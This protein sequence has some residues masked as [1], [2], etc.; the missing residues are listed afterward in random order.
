M[1]TP[2]GMSITK[3][4]IVGILGFL[5]GFGASYLWL[6]GKLSPRASVTAPSAQEG[7]GVA[8]E[9]PGGEVVKKIPGQGMTP[10]SDGSDVA[11]KIQEAPQEVTTKSTAT[12]GVVAGNSISV[13][14]QP[15]GGSITVAAVSIDKR[16]WIVIHQDDHGAPGWV[17]GARRLEPGSYTNDVVELL[18]A[19]TPGNVY[20]AML[21]TDDGVDTFDLHKDLPVTDGVGNPVMMRF[22]TTGQ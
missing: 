18:R 4:I 1:E 21:H 11:K 6:S 13:S 7:G 16:G 2:T 8:Q 17:L 15:A 19:T 3:V 20:Y 12:P 14:D 10:G 9:T 22:K 5:V